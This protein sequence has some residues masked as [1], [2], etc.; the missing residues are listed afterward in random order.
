MN[1]Y[2]VHPEGQ[3][4]FSVRTT[5]DVYVPVEISFASGRPVVTRYQSQTPSY[6]LPSPSTVRRL[7]AQCLKLGAVWTMPN[8]NRLWHDGCQYRV[9]TNHRTRE[10]YW[11]SPNYARALHFAKQG[12]A[13]EEIK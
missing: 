13:L 10:R 4:V 5:T 11:Q 9:T 12:Y 1:V 2:S 7:F 3:N 8:R 6:V